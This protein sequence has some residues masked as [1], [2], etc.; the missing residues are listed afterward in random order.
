M[1]RLEREALNAT[2]AAKPTPVRTGRSPGSLG[3]VRGGG[4][5][6]AKVLVLQGRGDARRGTGKGA[7]KEQVARF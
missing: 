4:G 2:V 3:A 1:E 7:G 6:G 5:F